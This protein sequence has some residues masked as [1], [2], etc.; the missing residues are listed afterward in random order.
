MAEMAVSGTSSS[1]HDIQCTQR[2]TTLTADALS[3]I[4]EGCA[5]LELAGLVEGLRSIGEEDLQETPHMTSKFQNPSE[6]CHKVKG[7]AQAPHA[8][9]E[10]V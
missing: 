1:K 3:M 8:K 5:P 7:H 6:S 2:H 10:S 9:V 4:L